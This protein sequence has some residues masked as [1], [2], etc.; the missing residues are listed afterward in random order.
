MRLSETEIAALRAAV[1]GVQWQ[2]IWLFGS[3]V[4]NSRR[5]GD[6]DILLHTGQPA[7]SVAHEVSSRYAAAVDGKLDVLVRPHPL[8]I[9]GT[10]TAWRFDRSTRTFSLSYNTARPKDAANPALL[11]EVFM[12]ARQYPKGYKVVITG[13]TQASAADAPVLLVRA[14]NGATAVKVTATPKP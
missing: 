1:K 2:H 14:L 6:I 12:P 3:R 4:D 11:T 10:P 7:F 8:A 13:G 5:G 9:S